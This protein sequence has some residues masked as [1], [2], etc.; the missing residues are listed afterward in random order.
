MG[1]AEDIADAYS[2]VGIGYTILRDSG[3]WSGEYMYAKPNSQITKPFIREFF[4]EVQMP[5]NTSGESGSLTQIDVTGDVFM[6]ANKTADI[7]I[8]L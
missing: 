8:N 4:L 6:V 5:W 7:N 3:N 2:E 1:V